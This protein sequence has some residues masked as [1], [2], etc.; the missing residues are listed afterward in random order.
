MATDTTEKGLEVLITNSLTSNGWLPGS[1]EDYDRT[2]CVD[3]SHLTAFLEATQP[4]TV[5]SLSLD[6]DT[7]TRRQF[8]SRLKREITSRGIID[9]LRKGIKHG[10]ND[11]TLF[12]GTPTPGNTAAEQ[13]YQQN[14]FSVTRQLRYSS[15]NQNSLD[16][17]LFINGLPVATM[18][19]KNRYTGQDVADAV[20]QY[21]TS[22]NAQEDLF[23]LGRCAVHLAVDDEEV[24]FCTHL[25]GR[26][27]EFLPFT[28]GKDDGS[29]GNPINPDGVKTAYL[30][31]EILTPE[32]L[33]DIVEN[34]AEK[35]GGRQIWPRY[36]QLDV[37]RKLLADVREKGAGQR[38][39]VQHSAGSGKSN[40]IAWTSRQLI[41]VEHDGHTAFDST[42]IITDRRNLDRQINDTIRLFAQVSSTV[43]HA[44][45]SG[46]LRRFIE[47]GKRIIIT[48][49]Q[50]F[51]F[52]LDDIGNE[53]RDRRFAIIID[54]AHSSQGGKASGAVGQALGQASDED[55]DSYEDQ[56]NRI[57]ES[58]RLLSNAS[59]F[60]FTATPKN[61][62]LELFGIP[63]PQADGT[64]RHLPFHSYTMKQAIQEEF[65]MDVLANYTPVNRYFNLIKS[66]EDDP[67]F[68]SRRAQKRLRQYVENHQH[69]ISEKAR[70]IV[71]HFNESVFIPKK[72]DGQARAM[73]V[74]DGVERAIRYYNAIRGIINEEGLPFKPLVAFSGSRRVEGLYEEEISE[75]QLNGF[76]ETRTEEEFRKDPYRILICAD[77]FQVGYDEPLLHTMYVDKHLSGIR[78]VQTLSRLNRSHPKKK[79]T[80][81]L[82]FMNTTDVI[83]ESFADY[84]RTT[85]LSDETDP[86]KLH[87]LKAGLD[88]AQVYTDEET[89]DVTQKYLNGTDRPALDPTIEVCA[90]KFREL[91]EDEKIKFK[92]TAKSFNRLYNFLSQVL[93]YANHSWEEL[94]IFL[95]LLLPKLPTLEDEDLAAGI[96]NAVDM[97]T[98]RTEKQA[99]ISIALVDEDAEIDPI[100][101]QRGGGAQDAQLEFLSII[102]DDFNKTWGNSFT[103]PDH[104]SEIIKAMPDRVNEDEAYQNAK[105]YSDKQN[106]RMEH[107]SA[108]RKQIIAS[109]KDSTELYKKYTEDQAFQA[110]LNELI[111]KLTYNPN[112][113]D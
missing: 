2:H 71:D 100:Q 38:Y 62:T 33:T 97:E 59:Y 102:L 46:D 14:R 103:N 109:L 3:L 40:S 53:H 22:R 12:Y 34:Y 25:R 107:D 1:P 68:D 72:I 64:V 50:K 63:D 87:D 6:S 93:P 7:P 18:E 94:S 4:E 48:T 15:S 24:E 85:I 43:A 73:V 70:I 101:A 80:F 21:Q 83:Q 20:E 13:R 29:A 69:A 44:D 99:T 98:Y 84:Y 61:K 49:V 19:L 28:K 5:A 67:E 108:L 104:V 9:I 39:L 77:K 8:L 95:T 45:R 106:A 90:E 66:V 110:D 113:T 54:E 88:Q 58:R 74:T 17:A 10:P 91:S 42:I 81:V 105:M 89:R 27:S 76:P 36:H 26:Q 75:A 78:A 41:D 79:D 111:F 57:I 31:E 55:D 37:T 52:I 56:V 112:Q 16:L 86:D 65:I 11:L 92:G 47:E 30:W 32:G 82:D 51:P 96:Q 35:V 60:A 23:R